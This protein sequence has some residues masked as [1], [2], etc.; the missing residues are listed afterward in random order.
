MPMD[1]SLS[2]A[3]SLSTTLFLHFLQYYTLSF[4]RYVWVHLCVYMRNDTCHSHLFCPTDDGSPVINTELTNMMFFLEKILRQRLL[5][6][7][8]LVRL[9]SLTRHID[10]VHD[11][12]QSSESPTFSL[13]SKSNKS[14]VFWSVSSRLGILEIS[15]QRVRGKTASWFLRN[16]P[17][18]SPT[19]LIFYDVISRMAKYSSHAVSA[20]F[21]FIFEQFA[22]KQ[23]NL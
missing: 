23:P 4:G 5:T 18:S 15:K 1:Y 10:D 22:T 11:P 19:P 21:D 13:R 8:L 20:K 14:N 7:L 16:S 2:C 3:T 6:H 9:V 12:F 17:P